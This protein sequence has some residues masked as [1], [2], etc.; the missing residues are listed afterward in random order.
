MRTEHELRDNRRTAPVLLAIAL[1]FFAGV[2]LKSV[3][4]AR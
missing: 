3:S 1:A 2:V 4:G